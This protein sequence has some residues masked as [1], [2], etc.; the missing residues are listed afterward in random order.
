[1]IKT[2]KY[3]GL[4]AILPLFT[5]ALTT[6]YIMEEADATKS[7]GSN[8][9]GRMATKSY[10]S[11]TSKIVCGDKLCSEYPGGY[12]QFQKDQGRSSKIGAE[13]ITPEIAEEEVT[14]EEEMMMEEPMMEEVIEEV[15]PGSI[16]R[17]SRANVPATI[18]MHQ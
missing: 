10:G 18:P 13:A 6:N 17:L 2:L 15:A 5:M 9:P 8:A 7:E 1:M 4:L 16:L 12:E 3:F 11:A 14:M